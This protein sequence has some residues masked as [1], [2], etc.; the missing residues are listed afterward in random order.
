VSR[1]VGIQLL[2]IPGPTNV[3]E[4]IARA[5]AR[6]LVDHRGQ[7]FGA[8]AR[9]TLAGLSDL[10]GTQS[11][12]A[13]FPSSG[14]GA[15]EAALVNTLSP[16]DAV[17]VCENGY[18][19]AQWA[20]LAERLGFQVV[21]LRGDWRRAPDPAVLA[22]ALGDDRAHAI[23]AV[24]LVHNETSTGVRASVPAIRG[25]L[26]RARHPALLLV[27]TISSLGST[28]YRHDEWGVDVSVG[29]SQKGLM[30]PPG[31]GLNAIGRKALA[32]S[33]RAGSPR[34][35]WDWAPALETARTGFFAYTPPTAL[36]VA[37]HEALAM[38]REEGLD[39]VFA[40]HERHAAATCAAV[41]AWGLEVYA[42]DPG[43]RSSTLTTVLLDEED[44][45][46]RLRA[47]AQERYG[48]S[49]GA[50]LDRLK[51]R[52][53]RIGHLGDFNDLMLC[54][55]LCGVELGLAATVKHH[56]SGGAAA[57]LVHLSPRRLQSASRLPQP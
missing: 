6:P 7:R 31:I 27:D 28:G 14:T 36:V 11:P 23:K 21:R 55:T 45:A 54:A 2:Q 10:F 43:E 49:L 41:E 12:V 20:R 25:A 38:L 5:L 1:E 16:G 47:H 48:L 44:D 51:G 35:Y 42:S 24:L 46:D 19:A 39:A 18:F 4:R 3:P 53:F 37:L 30:L 9:E 32:A 26:D 29:C 22:A 34:G 56:S 52:V 15:S 8:L 13:L 33:A 50:G 57:A 40:R 17:L